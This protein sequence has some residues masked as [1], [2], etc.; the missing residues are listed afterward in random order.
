MKNKDEDNPEWTDKMFEQSKPAKEVLPKEF[1]KKK[2]NLNY[3]KPWIGVDLDRTLAFYDGFVHELHIG[4]PVPEMV[5][6]VKKALSEGKKIKVFTARMSPVPGRN[7]D[8]VR[9]GIE[10]WC[11]EHIG[12]RLE[13]TNVKDF[14]CLELWDDIARQVVANTGEF[15]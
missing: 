7:L 5:E 12:E 4:D 15:K 6:K 8:E 9:K 13:V 3:Y 1:F 14:G 2:Q 11:E 10:D